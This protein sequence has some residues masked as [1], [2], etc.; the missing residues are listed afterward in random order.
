MTLPDASRFASARLSLLRAGARS[1]TSPTR[2]WSCCAST[3]SEPAALL[4]GTRDDDSDQV[5][6]VTDDQQMTCNTVHV[7]ALPQFSRAWL[8]S[9]AY[10]A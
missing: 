9:I 1:P 10:D 5:S 4:V 3:E 6:V 8:R 2:T 7:G